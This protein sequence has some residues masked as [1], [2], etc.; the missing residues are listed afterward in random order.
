MIYSMTRASA[1]ILCLV[2]LKESTG[3]VKP[4]VIPCSITHDGTYTNRGISLRM[5]GNE[6]FWAKQKVLMEEMS[7]STEKSLKA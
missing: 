6:D 2:I 4:P 7:R 1:S 3:F 5:A